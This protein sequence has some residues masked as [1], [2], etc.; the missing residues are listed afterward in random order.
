MDIIIKLFL[1]AYLLAMVLITILSAIWIL[2]AVFTPDWVKKKS[3]GKAITNVGSRHGF[4]QIFSGQSLALFMPAGLQI[5]TDITVV[6]ND[7]D[8]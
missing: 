4:D 7:E 2:T 8:C 3:F 6:S 1:L 5:N